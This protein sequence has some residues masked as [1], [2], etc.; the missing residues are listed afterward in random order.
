[1]VLKL[2]W[3]RKGKKAKSWPSVGIVKSFWAL[4]SALTCW[5]NLCFDTTSVTPF[6]KNFPKEPL[7]GIT[8]TVHLW[9]TKCLNLNLGLSLGLDLNLDDCRD[10]HPSLILLLSFCQSTHRCWTKMEWCVRWC[11]LESGCRMW[12]TQSSRRSNKNK[13]KLLSNNSSLR[14]LQQQLGKSFV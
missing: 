9:F 12:W 13:I 10:R 14:G 3:Q 2:S 5:K 6:Q 11:T 4:H 8:A 1:M 7:P